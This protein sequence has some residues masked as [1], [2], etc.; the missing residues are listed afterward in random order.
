M[1]TLPPSDAGMCFY[2]VDIGSCIMLC[3]AV[4][5]W[6][7]WA[8]RPERVPLSRS[9]VSSLYPSSLCVVQPC[10]LPAGHPAG[11]SWMPCIHCFCAHTAPPY[12]GPDLPCSAA[13]AAVKAP[14]AV[15]RDCLYW[16]LLMD[17]SADA[18]LDALLDW[19]M[20]C[21]TCQ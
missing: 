21:T 18:L 20:T 5:C 1:Q 2:F 8:A 6:A 19:C 13:Q 4:L 7:V 9:R 17:M 11:Q 3:G 10:S 12:E 15:A 16:S 14:Q